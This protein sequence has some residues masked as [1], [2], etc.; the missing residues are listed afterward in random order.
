ME[1]SCKELRRPC[2]NDGDQAHRIAASVEGSWS[3]C[4]YQILIFKNPW[5]RKKCIPQK[6]KKF[7]GEIE[8]SHF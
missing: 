3:T 1:A 2:S 5:L 7:A 6:S 8:K 4:D